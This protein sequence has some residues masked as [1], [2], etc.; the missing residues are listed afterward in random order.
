MANGEQTRFCDAQ[1]VK[2]RVNEEFF[3]GIRDGF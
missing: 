1:C 3:V 2:A